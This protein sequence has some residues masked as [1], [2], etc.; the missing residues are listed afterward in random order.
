ME[1]I[2]RFRLTCSR[3]STVQPSLL[4]FQDHFIQI[5][6]L[7]LLASTQLSNQSGKNSNS[8][9]DFSSITADTRGKAPA[10]LMV[11]PG[12]QTQS[13]P[14]MHEKELRKTPERTG[15]SAYLMLV[16]PS[17]ILQ[18][19]LASEASLRHIPEQQSRMSNDGK[20]VSTSSRA[21]GCE[22]DTPP[23]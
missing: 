7:I 12:A 19:K 3:A 22:W 10:A 1:S 4:F 8:S 9:S 17:E 23:C 18:L 13:S 21:S 2:P 14:V 20:P 16:V 11:E 6:Q 5:L 15:R